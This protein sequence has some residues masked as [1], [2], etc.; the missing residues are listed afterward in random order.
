MQ[1]IGTQKSN[2][3]RQ[4]PRFYAGYAEVQ[5]DTAVQTMQVDIATNKKQYSPG[6]TVQL[7]VSTKDSTGKLVDARVSLAVIDAALLSLYDTIKEPIPYFF[8]KLGTSVF[9]YSNMKLLYQS[10]KAF[11][12]AGSK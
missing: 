4:E 2:S 3:L 1:L 8:N 11:A 7:T 5:V 9:S 6:E 12:T 10:L